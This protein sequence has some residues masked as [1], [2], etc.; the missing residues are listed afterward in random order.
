MAGVLG[1]L[2]HPPEASI[3]APPVRVLNIGNN[4]AERVN[5]LISLLEE[6]LGKKAVVLHAPRPAADV[7]E[8]F[9][10]VSAIGAL[11]GYAPTT[12][13]EVGIPRFVAWFRTFYRINA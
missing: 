2:D 5:T 10:D 1:C 9:A 8:T 4:R 13:L 7:E 6:G 3:D 12:P 11:T